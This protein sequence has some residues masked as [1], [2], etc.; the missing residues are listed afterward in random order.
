MTAP[1]ERRGPRLRS[2]CVAEP[3]IPDHGAHLSQRGFFGSLP[4]QD[5]I[6]MPCTAL[7]GATRPPE[8]K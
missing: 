1:R 7:R 5:T 4:L 8:H 3:T 6:L 2:S